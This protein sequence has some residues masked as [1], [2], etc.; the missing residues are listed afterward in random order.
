MTYAV[1]AALQSAI[2]ETL[3]TDPVLDGLVGTAIY[4]AVPAGNLPSLYV[5]LGAEA[6]ADA[7]DKTGSGAVHR[8]DVTIVSETP[9]FG[10]AKTVAAAV[11]D[12]LLAADISLT[13]GRLVSLNFEKA[14][15]GRIDGAAGRKIDLT[16]RAR[17]EDN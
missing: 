7:S 16:F 17:V 11:S 2:Y 12:A 8:L 1:S 9:A 14:R 13:R 4:D 3:A 5:T 6:V 15:A 10:A